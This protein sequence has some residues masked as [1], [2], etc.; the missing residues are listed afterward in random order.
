MDK[1]K[2]CKALYALSGDVVVR[3]RKPLYMPMA[4]F[5]IGAF[6]VALNGV[7][8]TELSNNLQSA[9]VFTGGIIALTGLILLASRLLGSEGAPYHTEEQCYLRYEELYF[10][11]NE[12]QQVIDDVNAGAVELLLNGKHTHIPTVAVALY[13]TPNNRFA[14]MQAFEYADFEYRPL[15]ELRVVRRE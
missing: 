4:L 13:H 15:T 11:H 3:R 5:A 12:L 10:D 9:V 2:I 7:Y 6:A 8:A 1:N 14:A